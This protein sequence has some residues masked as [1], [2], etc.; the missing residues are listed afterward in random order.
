M[1]LC[2]IRASIVCSHVCLSLFQIAFSIPI[3]WLHSLS[4]FSFDSLK[5]PGYILFSF[6]LITN[7]VS[8]CIVTIT[9][10][11]NCSH[12]FQ[13]FCARILVPL[14]FIV[15][16]VIL[17]FG[18]YLS[19][20]DILRLKKFDNF[21]VDYTRQKKDPMKK[22]LLYACYMISATF[23]LLI[24]LLSLCLC[25]NL[26]KVSNQYHSKRREHLSS[27]TNQTVSSNDVQAHEE[28]NAV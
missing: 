10:V 14:V 26:F 11:L 16:M 1:C 23:C 7:I 28:I 9:L 4:G 13:F 20:K 18:L 5:L 24:T 3:V 21:Y 15:H 22:T 2:C 25:N 19:I 8:L 12:R 6:V 17:S 27:Q